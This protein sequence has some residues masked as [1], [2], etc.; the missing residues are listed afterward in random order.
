M[1]RNRRVRN[2]QHSSHNNHSNSSSNRGGGGN[3]A[4]R[5]K[6]FTSRISEHFS[7]RDFVCQCGAC[8]QSIKISLGLV[9]GLELLRSKAGKRIT[10]LKGYQCQE[11]AE[12]EGS[13]KRNFYTTGVAAKISV[14]E[15]DA[16]DVFLLA[17]SV[18]EFMGIGLNLDDNSV[19]VDTRKSDERA[20]WVIEH[21][22]QIELSEDNRH[23]YF[24]VNPA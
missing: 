4:R 14:D 9:G 15:T 13:F 23:R 11:S 20:L 7:K 5:R 3:G 17:E 10:I 19:I 2:R 8:N 12:A 1:S 16:K 24:A 22:T 6:R 21:G 18:P